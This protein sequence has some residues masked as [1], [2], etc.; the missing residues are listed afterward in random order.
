MLASAGFLILHPHRFFNDGWF[1]AGIPFALLF[2]AIVPYFIPSIIAFLRKHENALP[3][4]LVNIFLGW[5]LIG[6]IICLV[7]A[8]TGS[9]NSGTVTASPQAVAKSPEPTPPPPPVEKRFCTQC[10]TS[11]DPT[12]AFCRRCGTKI[13]S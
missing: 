11:G 10:G 6:W 2:A 13:G 3:L 7:W 8:L 1:L 12:D 9:G 4:F 5:T